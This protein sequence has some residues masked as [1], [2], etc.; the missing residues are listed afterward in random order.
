MPLSDISYEK[1][2]K[3][4]GADVGA[5]RSDSLGGPR[6][7]AALKRE[8]VTQRPVLSDTDECALVSTA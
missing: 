3:L 4:R 8:R 2:S 1:V 7:L 5:M 6:W